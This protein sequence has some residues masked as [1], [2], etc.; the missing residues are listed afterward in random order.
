MIKI[1]LSHIFLILSFCS[2]AF[3]QSLKIT[4]RVFDKE[5]NRIILNCMIFLEPGNQSTVTDQSG[6]YSFNCQPGRKRIFTRV[7]GY[8]PAEVKFNVFSDTII[9]LYIRV[10]PYKLSEV[11]VVADSVKSIEITS[12]GS[13]LITPA[14]LFETPK[15]FSE[16][17]LLKSFQFL[18]GVSAGKDGSSDIYIRGGSAG[19]NIVLANGCYFFLPS[20]L[21]GFVSP[22]DIDFLESAELIKDYFP[23][24]LGGGAASI[25]S[26]SYR[27]SKM[28]SLSALVRIG[29]L[30]SG[31]TIDVPL[32]KINSGL[33]AGLKRSN[34]S[35]Y[36]P[37]L[38]KIVQ[39]AEG[40]LPPENYS[41]YDGYLR[42]AHTSRRLGEINYLFLG[43]Y[44]NGSKQT[45]TEAKS[46][47]FDSP[48][49]TLT[50]IT[51]DISTGWNNMVHAIQWKLPT[52][53]LL[54][55]QLD[56]CYNRLALYRKIKNQVDLQRDEFNIR[57]TS[58]TY[59]LFPI[60]NNFG[61]NF[62]VI[63]ESR[64]LSFTTG[65]SFRLRFFSPLVNAENIVN[66]VNIQN[67]FGE[68]RVVSEPVVY[69]STK[70]FLSKKLQAD[71]GLRL[72]WAFTT[73]VSFLITEPRL[74]LSFNSGSSISPHINYVRLSQ[75]DHYLEGSNVGLR[76]NL[77]TP[78]SKKIG[79]EV[80]DVISTGFQGNINDHFVWT[81]DAYYKSISGMVDFKSGASFLYDT[82]FEDMLDNVR[83]RAYGLE[84]GFI[85]RTGK[86]TGSVCY[87]FSRSER[88]WGSPEGLTW[89]PSNA[90]RP[91]N[92]NI[93]MKYYFKGNMSFGFNWV[94]LT[95]SP[96]T[97]Y[98]HNS[99]L[100][101]WYETKNNI[102]YFDY[103]RLDLS[104]RKIFLLKSF[105]IL[106]DLDVYNVY[107]RKNT[108]YFQQIYDKSNKQTIYKNVS[109]FPVMPSLTVTIK[110]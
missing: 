83:G 61:S 5:E 102:R 105:S 49:D 41:F 96:A 75:L 54:K 12:R 23:A 71:V 57:T 40:F 101:E 6:R 33:T 76:S 95:G 17:D 78:V 37:F 35:L 107:N 63:S 18:P 28:D 72:T 32:K 88:E 109:L 25:I 58:T 91:Q 30:S 70:L 2:D 20:H 65:F 80:S 46:S 99:I 69:L 77:W 48:L 34:Y 38:K 60:S 42:I 97:I 36:A 3:G 74:R 29:I 92:A 87:T 104:V 26:L 93:S 13:Y 4:G 10:S 81:L 100:G 64:I 44:D 89:I 14:A 11:R 8:E 62:F 108:Y 31:I 98:T 106:L 15:L 90:D 43:N 51:D 53:G 27:K 86:L 110:Y 103:H 94:Y 22:Y 66:N 47:V 45:K 55:W 84:A 85:K 7:M 1:N 82:L 73:D 59:S 50:I 52:R 24:E 21:L 68:K 39:R 16:P 19:Q 79:P 9:D 67:S 56:L